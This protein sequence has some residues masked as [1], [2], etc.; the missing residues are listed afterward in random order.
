MTHRAQITRQA[1]GD[2]V[3]TPT[4]RDDVLAHI[5]GTLSALDD[6][7]HGLPFKGGKALRLRCF[8]DYR[9]SAHVDFS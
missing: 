4:V 8:E 2:G 9:Y 6:N 3:P 7:S 5:I 1:A